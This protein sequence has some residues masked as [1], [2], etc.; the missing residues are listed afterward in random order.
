V[1]LVYKR[2]NNFVYEFTC[3]GG[4]GFAGKLGIQNISLLAYYRIYVLISQGSGN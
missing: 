1:N 2:Q 4:A 3:L